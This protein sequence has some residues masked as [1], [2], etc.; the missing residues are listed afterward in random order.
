MFKHT[1]LQLLACSRFKIWSFS[2][3]GTVVVACSSRFSDDET[4]VV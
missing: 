1:I 4:T 2:D 3:E